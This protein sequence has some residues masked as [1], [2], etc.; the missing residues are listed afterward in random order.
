[1]ALTNEII[2]LQKQLGFDLIGII[3]VES[4]KYAKN[5]NAWL[6]RGYAGEMDWIRQG[7]E[8]RLNPLEIF[9]EA[10][11]VILAGINYYL[12]DLPD[13]IKNDPSRGIIAR[14]AWHEDYHKLVVKKLEEFAG[15]L[16][17]ILKQKVNSKSYVDTGPI[18]EREL[19]Y[20]AGLGFIGNNTN[21]INYQL[22][23][24]LF[25]GEIF[26]D[27]ALPSYSPK[28]VGSCGTCQ[29][30]LDRCPT[31]A[32]VDKKLLDARKC[33]S[34]L[35]IELK[36][37]IPEKF[38]P[39]MKNR[40]FGCDICQEVC[41]WNSKAEPALFFGTVGKD[42]YPHL[43]EDQIAPSLLEL[44]KLSEVEFQERFRGKPM[45]RAKYGGFMRN[46][47][48]ALGNW[49]SKPALKGVECLLNNSDPIIKS[50]ALW[51]KKQILL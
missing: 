50:H 49:G 15:Q 38:R 17:G 11:S 19:A 47:A 29:R 51:A 37:E 8:K 40:I 36:G 32:L 4:S 20:R 35:T 34:Y 5:L 22:G 26:L 28:I 1:M 3:P 23:S 30:C 13:E 43:L 27:V 6:K 39:L 18:L 48:I 9:P 44:A 2:E 25:L 16:S 14:Y 45:L 10:K 21:L 7:K 41:P 31:K 46:V 33:L 42:M 12:Q 24:Y